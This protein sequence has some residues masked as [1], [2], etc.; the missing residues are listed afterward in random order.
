[1]RIPKDLGEFEDLVNWDVYHGMHNIGSS[2][3]PSELVKIMDL[4]S[5][6]MTKVTSFIVFLC[7]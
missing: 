7:F 2:L 6:L 4:R 3:L 1:V 5:P